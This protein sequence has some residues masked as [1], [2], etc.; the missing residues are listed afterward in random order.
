MLTA[1]CRG[2]A[3]FPDLR[4]PSTLGHRILY[5]AAR[6]T[7][8]G[9]R[10]RLRASITWPW[11]DAVADTWNRITA[12]SYL[13]SK[14]PSLR[15]RKEPGQVDPGHLAHSR[16]PS[17]LPKSRSAM[18]RG[19][20]PGPA[21]DQRERSGRARYQ[22][23]SVSAPVKRTYRGDGWPRPGGAPGLLVDVSAIARC[24]VT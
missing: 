3:G 6:L 11:A 18:R 23:H 24:P 2:I 1:T 15:S 17:H 22:A 12:Q 8:S 19:S 13:T 10:R 5:V 7:R 21:T 20:H 4:P 16:A 9:R 14:E